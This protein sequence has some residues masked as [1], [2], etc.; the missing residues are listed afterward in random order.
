[1]TDQFNTPNLESIKSFL[2]DYRWEYKEVNPDNKPGLVAPYILEEKI[3]GQTKGILISFRIEGEFVIVT[4][5][6]LLKNVPISYCKRFLELNDKI[7]LVKLYVSEQQDSDSVILDMGFELWG[8]SWNKDTFE[9][10][11]D[12]LTLHIEEILEIAKAENIPHETHFIDI[13][14][15]S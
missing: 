5:T 7:K 2:S 12:M 4:T 11:M 14:Y 10:F 8:G 6:D 3:E 15:N 13:E 1:M 9:A